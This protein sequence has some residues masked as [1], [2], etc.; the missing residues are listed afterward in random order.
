MTQREQVDQFAKPVVDG[1]GRVDV[2][3]NNAGLMLLPPLA[4]LKVEE[5]E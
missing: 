3:I 2:L 4:A 5:W 1:F